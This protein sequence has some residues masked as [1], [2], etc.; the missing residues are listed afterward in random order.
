M[1]TYVKPYE[2]KLKGS[3]YSY[4][5]SLCNHQLSTKEY[6]DR[7]C[8]HC[9]AYLDL[10]EPTVLDNRTGELVANDEALEVLRSNIP[11]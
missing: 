3:D 4:F 7:M 11:S 9:G 8:R 5:C 1:V 6:D 10:Y 2:F